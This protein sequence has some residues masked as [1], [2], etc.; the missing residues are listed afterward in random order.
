MSLHNLLAPNSNQLVSFGWWK[1]VSCLACAV[2]LPLQAQQ[3]APAPNIAGAAS[4]STEGEAS[5][6]QQMEDIYRKE[7]STR[8]IPLLG[9]YLAELQRLSAQNGPGK[10]AYMAEIS[11]VQQIISSGGVVDLVAAQQAQAGNAAMPAP[12]TP[13]IPPERKQALIA[14][15]PSLAQS[16]VPEAKP[17]AA[18]ALVSQAE[19]RIER[20]DAGEYDVL[21]QYSCPDLKD[22][23]AVRVELAGQSVEKVL[24]AERATQDDKTFRISRLG[25]LNLAGDHR[26]ETLRLLAGD[27]NNPKII[28][29]SV[30]ITRPRQAAN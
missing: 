22:P 17:E 14:L 28:L 11:R 7:L 16:F 13:A 10:E 8:H 6:L 21:L 5:R 20:I 1:S 19:W 30:L 9:K 26:G 29:K 27:K 4:L 3:P 24:D 18:A 15:A 23:V 2:T 25:T 12:P